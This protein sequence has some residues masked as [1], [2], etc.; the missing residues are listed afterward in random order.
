DQTRP[1]W[2]WTRNEILFDRA[3]HA[4]SDF[5][6]CRVPDTGQGWLAVG[7]EYGAYPAW[8]ARGATFA[9]NYEPDHSVWLMNLNDGSRIDQ[10]SGRL[11]GTASPSPP[12]IRAGMPC[13]GPKGVP[14]VAFAAQPAIANWGV[15]GNGYNQNYNYIF[16]LSKPLH[17]IWGNA[18]MEDGAPT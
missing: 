18:P 4:S 8:N 13:I 15:P 14:Q 9:V 3:A 5:T 10:L 2:R 1:D 7:A 12:G 6:V 11:D 17:G 16:V